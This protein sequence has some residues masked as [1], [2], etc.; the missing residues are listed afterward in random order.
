MTAGSVTVLHGGYSVLPEESRFQIVLS[1]HV[2]QHIPQ[3]MAEDLMGEMARRLEPGGLLI[4]TTTCTDGAEDLF[5]R[6]RWLDGARHE[7]AIDGKTFD[8][9]F[10]LRTYCP[11]GSS[12]WTR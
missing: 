7:E 9:T 5:F 12:R 1:S 2:M 3:D 4:L 10:G 6:E 8:E 11:C